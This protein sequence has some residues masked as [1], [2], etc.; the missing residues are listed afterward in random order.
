ME[1]G[2]TGWVFYGNPW[3]FALPASNCGFIHEGHDAS[4]IASYM[5]RDGQ[6]ILVD[7]NQGLAAHRCL[8]NVTATGAASA[9]KLSIAIG[10]DSTA[11]DNVQWSM[12]NGQSDLWYTIDGRKL[13]G[14][15]TKKGLY[16]HNGVKT[17]IK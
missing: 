10:D 11:I 17:V 1:N 13:S 9:R 14:K 16:I 15:P 2:G 3:T 4:G 8:L 7:E 5:L 12:F 6:F